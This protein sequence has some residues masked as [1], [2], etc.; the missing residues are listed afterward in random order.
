MLLRDCNCAIEA[1]LGTLRDSPCENKLF[2]TQT[3]G[4]AAYP[5]D[6]YGHRLKYFGRGFPEP[7]ERVAERFL[8]VLDS[9]RYVHPFQ[10]CSKPWSFC[11]RRPVGCR[12]IYCLSEWGCQAPEPGGLA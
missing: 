11:L 5:V 7:N 1:Q 10:G 9:E 12:G 4:I 6:Y 3:V 2:S 8:R